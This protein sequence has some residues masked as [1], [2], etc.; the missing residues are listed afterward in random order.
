MDFHQIIVTHNRPWTPLEIVSFLV[1]LFF[2]VLVIVQLLNKKI[3]IYSQALAGLA[4]IFY[5][6]IVF[7]S[8]VFTRKTGTRA[9]NLELLLCRGLFEWDDIIHNGIGC[10][11]GCLLCNAVWRR[12][13]N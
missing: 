3:I 2:A 8:T 4:L 9:Y 12:K 6:G 10:L 5:L 13:V 7:A 11:L 1:V